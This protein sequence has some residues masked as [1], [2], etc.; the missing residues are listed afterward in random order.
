[1]PLNSRW[2]VRLQFI[3]PFRSGKVGRGQRVPLLCT[4]YYIYPARIRCERDRRV[5]GDAIHSILI[6]VIWSMSTRIWPARETHEVGECLCVY[7]SRSS[8]GS[9]GNLWELLRPAKTTRSG[10]EFIVSIAAEDVLLLYKRCKSEVVNR[11]TYRLCRRWRVSWASGV[12]W[13]REEGR[14]GAR[15]KKK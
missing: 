2:D 9:T 6:S 10:P 13:Q 14:R 11:P 4:P 7:L 3:R 1:M 12:C 8:P 5:R 15:N